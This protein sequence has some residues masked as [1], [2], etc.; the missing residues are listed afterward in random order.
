MSKKDII[1]SEDQAFLRMARICSRKEY[2]PFDISQKLYR[3]GFSNEVLDKII[4]KLITENYINEERF[5]RSFV[6]DKLLINRWGVKK[7]EMHLRYKQLSQNVIDEILSEYTNTELNSS[8]KSILIKKWS[9]IKGE[10]NYEKKGKLIKYALG[11]GFKMDAIIK[12]INNMNL[13]EIDVD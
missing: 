8:L 12:C 13:N 3:L 5:V 2:S 4:G 10:S 9:Q 1:I 11:R 6:S 7:I